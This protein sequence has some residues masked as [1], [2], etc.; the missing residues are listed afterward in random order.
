M[1]LQR[2]PETPTP[3]DPP[4]FPGRRATA[5]RPEH[6]VGGRCRR[7]AI[8]S[9]VIAALAGCAARPGLGPEGTRTPVDIAA[10]PWRSLGLVATEAGGRCTGAL[11][12]PRAVLTAAH[13]VFNPRTARP[14]DAGS[15]HFLLGVSPQGHAG[16]ARAR[17]IVMGPGFTVA[18]GM[19]PDPA[20]APDADWAVLV[21]DSALGEPERTL[22][23]A[24]GYPR[25]GTALAFGGYQADR[26]RQMVADLA[27]AVLGYGR[28]T[29]GRVMMRHSCAATSGA[30][31]GPLLVRAPSGQ[32]WVVAG[33]G[34]LA[35]NGVSGGWAVPTAAIARAAAMAPAR[36]AAP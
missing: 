8:W 34:S 26:A 23:L 32:A 17:S 31:G 1:D 4:P 5:R 3:A 33:V 9:S 20:T 10:A 28:D 35:Q 30:S 15:V 22:P 29:A 19:R 7:L 6:G 13:C 27:C 2:T 36:T 25:P 21:F 16:H 11:V 18:P 24:A 14:V 12:A